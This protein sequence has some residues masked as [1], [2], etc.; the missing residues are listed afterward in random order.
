MKV[1]RRAVRSRRL[2]RGV[3]LI[4]VILVLIIVVGILAAVIVNFNDANSSRQQART[5][6]MI[7]QVYSSVQDLYRNSATYGTAPNDLIEELEATD[8]LPPGAAWTAGSPDEI[9]TPI[10]S[11]LTVQTCAG[12]ATSCG[13]AAYD[14][15]FFIFSFDTVETEDC[16][17][18][19]TNYVNVGSGKV[20]MVAYGYAAAISAATIEDVDATF[21]VGEVI[22]ECDQTTD[23]DLH[24]VYN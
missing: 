15:Q 3:T 21:N 24:L 6:T 4:E 10:G 16:V 18:L 17:A 5:V 8:S 11:D 20:T 19:L 23:L 13:A 9:T 12:S 14:E 7:N 22:T 1:F 2:R